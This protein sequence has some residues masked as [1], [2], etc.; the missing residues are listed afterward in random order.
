MAEADTS[1]IERINYRGR[2]T[3]THVLTA[4]NA[5]VYENKETGELCLALHRYGDNERAVETYE[6][7]LC[8]ADR[9]RLKPFLI[10]R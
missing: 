6:F 9:E 7:R 4:D 8:A 1:T 2:E 5:S 3:R 10:G